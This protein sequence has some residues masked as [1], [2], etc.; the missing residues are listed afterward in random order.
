MRCQR[1]GSRRASPA[2]GRSEPLRML[3][4]PSEKPACCRFVLAAWACSD[5]SNKVTIF[6]KLLM[7]VSFQKVDCIGLSPLFGDL[8]LFYWSA[9]D[10]DFLLAQRHLLLMPFG[11]LDPPNMHLFLEHQAAFHFQYF[12]N[13]RDDRDLAL[14]A[15]GWH[16][17][18]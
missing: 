17:L 14:L 18:D 7:G 4:S 10:E 6:S 16:S 9:G 2:L 11:R 3:M 8:R 1:P 15:Y 5:V 13:D 12:L